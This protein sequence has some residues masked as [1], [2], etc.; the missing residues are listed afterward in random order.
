MFN[1][2]LVGPPGSGKGTQ[3]ERM[4]QKYRFVPIALG[5]LLRQQMAENGANKVLIETYINRG[6]LVPDHL[7]FELVTGLVQGQPADTSFLFDGFP[8]TIPQVTFLDNFLKQCDAKIDGVI[9]LDVSNSILL[10]RL[11]NR[12]TIE[13]RPDDQDDSKIK[14]RMQIYEQ[15]TLSILN[16]YKTQGKLHSIDGTKS[17]DAVTQAIEAIMD[18][19]IRP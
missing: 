16:Y 18:G 17:V 14:T 8:R 4:I 11:K 9:F 10:K 1:I 7:S 5:A 12:A 3:A 19:L 6:Q 2:I 13:A 15:E